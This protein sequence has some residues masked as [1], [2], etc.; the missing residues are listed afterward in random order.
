MTTTAP[1]QLQFATLAEV[2]GS[3]LRVCDRV[4]VWSECLVAGVRTQVRLGMKSGK[5]VAVR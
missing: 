4:G 5:V 2:N 1:R 3:V